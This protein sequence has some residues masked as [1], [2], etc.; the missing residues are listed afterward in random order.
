MCD[1]NDWWG[2]TC[3]GESP[4]PGDRLW[5]ANMGAYGSSSAMRFL[6]PLAPYIL[7][8]QDGAIRRL[9]ERESF[10]HRYPDAWFQEA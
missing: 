4:A 5:I 3:W 7:L 10:T 1:P 6:F 2:D 9:T 8:A